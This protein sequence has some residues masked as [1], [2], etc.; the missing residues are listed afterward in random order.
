MAVRETASE[1]LTRLL[2]LS[3][4]ATGRRALVDRTGMLTYAE[5]GAQSSRVAHL[6]SEL[7]VVGA[8]GSGS[9]WRS[10]STRWPGC[11]GC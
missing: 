5:L 7:G 9:T 2:E 3:A 10:R 4:E 8:T 11:T 1:Q 6:L